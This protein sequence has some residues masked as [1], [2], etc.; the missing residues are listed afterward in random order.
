MTRG[1]ATN[2]HSACQPLE[3]DPWQ[4]CVAAGWSPGQ[5]EPGHQTVR[6][7][8]YGLDVEQTDQPELCQLQAAP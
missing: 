3:F 7:C 6:L 4:L 8:W 2:H 1:S 5:L